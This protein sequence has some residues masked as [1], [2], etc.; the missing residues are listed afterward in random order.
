MTRKT[1]R[2]REVYVSLTLRVAEEFLE[3]LDQWRALH[4]PGCRAPPQSSQSSRSGSADPQMGDASLL[5]PRQFWIPE[6]ARPPVLN[7]AST[8]PQSKQSQAVRFA[9]PK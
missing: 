9:C 4:S 1:A 6:V 8:F 7:G 2:S 5:R 3:R